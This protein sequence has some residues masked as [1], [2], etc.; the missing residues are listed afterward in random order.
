MEADRTTDLS[1]AATNTEQLHTM[2]ALQNQL[3]RGHGPRPRSD[4]T[5]A[6]GCGE[7]VEPKRLQLGFGLTVEC[8]RA[9]ELKQGQRR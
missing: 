3:A 6:C 8:A 2:A 7:E 4:G 9:R 5:C 1:D